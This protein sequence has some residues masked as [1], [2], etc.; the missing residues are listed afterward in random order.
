G[1]FIANLKVSR[2][3]GVIRCLEMVSALR[4]SG[5]PIIVGAHVG[6]TSI[7]TRAGMC[8]ANAAGENLAAQEGGYGL[9]IL[10]KEP[11]TPSLMFGDFGRI[12]LREPYQIKTPDK[13]IEVPVKHWDSG[14]G[15]KHSP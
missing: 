12:N 10:K 15:L 3:G 4:K 7:L 8:V 9:L 13:V 6:E 5:Y 2:L 1:N 11:L 14:W